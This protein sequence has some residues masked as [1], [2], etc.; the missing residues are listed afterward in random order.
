MS[1]RRKQGKYLNLVCDY[2]PCSLSRFNL[3]SRAKLVLSPKEEHDSL[4]IKRV[5]VIRK[6]CY[7]FFEGLA[8]LHSKGIAHRDIKP[9]NIL[10]DA[11]GVLN[12]QKEPT[13]KIC[14]FGSAKTLAN[15]NWVFGQQPVMI[16]GTQALPRGSVTYISTR[17]Y[18]SPELLYGNA[19]YGVEIDLWAA[20]CVLAELFSR[21]NHKAVF[22]QKPKQ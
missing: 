15:H 17:Y 22:S 20:G 10:V 12:A 4:H 1:G 6:L 2:M 18:R 13:L 3:N 16:G 11:E 5:G 19:Y 7:Q 9:D 14:D 8:F 21:G